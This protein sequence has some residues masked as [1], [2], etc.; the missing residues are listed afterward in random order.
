MRNANDV[1]EEAVSNAVESVLC[2][3]RFRCF[4]LRAA[5]RR[6]CRHVIT[7]QAQYATVADTSAFCEPAVREL[8]C[9]FTAEK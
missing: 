1:G 6:G 9:T 5:T 8:A 4:V 7:M 3:E 2:A